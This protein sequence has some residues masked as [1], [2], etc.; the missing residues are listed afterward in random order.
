VDHHTRYP[1]LV[2][3]KS[4]DYEEAARA[5]YQ[6]WIVHYGIPRAIIHDQG[7]AFTSEMFQKLMVILGIQNL[8][9]AAHHPACNGRV[10]RNNRVINSAL[11][12]V[13][14]ALQT[15]WDLRLTDL[16]F[17]MRTSPHSATGVS[18]MEMMTGFAPRLPTDIFLCAPGTL[19]DLAERELVELPLRIRQV[20]DLALETSEIYDRHRYSAEFRNHHSVN[21]ETDSYV[22]LKVPA[23]AV[24]GQKLRLRGQGLPRE[25]G[26]RGDLYAVL[27]V[28]VPSEVS[29]EE[30]KAWEDLAKM[31]RW[32]PKGR[33]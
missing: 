18:P 6:G 4:T 30:K 7:S 9:T 26:G 10:E 32:R 3:T 21:F 2:A 27:E 16:E 28:G 11:T 1:A 8:Q 29:A 5:L 17:A 19:L 22:M 15:D 12:H 25:D 20:H 33:D 24:G 13:V 31:S 14:N 23:G